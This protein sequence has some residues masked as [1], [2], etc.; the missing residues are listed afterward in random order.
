MDRRTEL[1]V[2]KNDEFL[3]LIRGDVQGPVWRVFTRFIIGNVA[4][5]GIDSN[6]VP[7]EEPAVSIETNDFNDARTLDN[8]ESTAEAETNVCF[9]NE[10][11]HA[12]SLNN[13]SE[14]NYAKE[15]PVIDMYEEL[16]VSEG[17]KNI[18]SNILCIEYDN[19]YYEINENE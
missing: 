7:S 8:Q 4:T 1:D 9:E 14:F 15:N 12:E 2:F 17:S 5:D 3:K 19:L 10:H 16:F 6:Q 11:T 13:E 18:I